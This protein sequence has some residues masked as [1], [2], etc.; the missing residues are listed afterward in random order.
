MA[1]NP[2]VELARDP[3][4][5]FAWLG[6]ALFLSALILT[7]LP[8]ALRKTAWLFD[9][10]KANKRSPSWWS[11]GDSNLG[12]I[13]PPGWLAWSFAVLFVLAVTAWA[14]GALFWLVGV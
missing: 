6:Y 1:I 11:F 4:A 8:W 12:Y 13:P 3:V 5:A 2:F 7:A 14:L 9:R 10:W